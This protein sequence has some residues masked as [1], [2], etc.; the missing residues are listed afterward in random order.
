RPNEHPPIREAATP[1]AGRVPHWPC[2]TFDPHRGAD[3]TESPSHAA[4]RRRRADLRAR[5]P[6][7][8]QRGFNTTEIGSLPLE[9]SLTMKQSGGFNITDRRFKSTRELIGYLVRAAGNV[10]DLGAS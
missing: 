6:R 2:C 4:R 10:D 5:P 3:R 7:L 8:Q 9:T 1:T